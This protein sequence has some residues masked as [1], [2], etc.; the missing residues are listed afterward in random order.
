MRPWTVGVMAAARAHRLADRKLDQHSGSHDWNAVAEE[1]EK[2]AQYCR[3][4]AVDRMVNELANSL[5]K[6]A[7]I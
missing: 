4:Q 1:L 6:G 5:A 7:T 2:A 3:N